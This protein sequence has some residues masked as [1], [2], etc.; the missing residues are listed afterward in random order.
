M[1]TY[2]LGIIILFFATVSAPSWALAPVESLVL[3][4]FSESYNEELTDPLN[5]V[6]TRDESVKSESSKNKSAMAM[7]RGFY[8]EGKNLTNY[9]KSPRTIRYAS[10]WDKLQVKRSTLALVQYIGLDLLSRAIPQYAKNL[11]FNR[12]DYTNLAENLVGNYCSNNLSVISK[13]ELLNNLFLK[14]DKENRFELPGVNK[15]II[16]PDNE[17]ANY[18][19]SK[20]GLEQEFL[21]SIK[22]FQ[23]VCSWNGNPNSAGLMA[24]I[25]RHSALMSFFIRQMSNQAIGWKEQDNTLFLKEDLKTVQVWCENLICRKVDAATFPQKVIYSVGGTNIGEDLKRL[26]CEE[27]SDETYRPEDYDDRIAKIM[28]KQSFDEQNFINSQFI[29]LITNVPDFLLRAP[30]FT[31]GED[32]LRASVDSTWNQWARKMS[33]SQSRDLFFEEPLTMEL[34]DR[35]RLHDFRKNEYR[36]GFDINL[37]EFDRINEQIGKVKL[38][39]LIKIPKAFIKYYR[40]AMLD[41]NYGHKTKEEKE[42]LKKRMRLHVT[43]DVERAKERFIIPPWR[44]D[45][46]G[47]IVEEL[48]AQIMEKA[49]KTMEFEAIGEQDVKV[50]V[51]YGV[52][53]LKY[54]NHQMNVLKT[55]EKLQSSSKK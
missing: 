53:A 30:K 16:Y 13:K 44:G 20:T 18:L 50:E 25:I 41:V 17:M 29:S 14:F 48:T 6:F 9:C 28:N 52:F 34:I 8:E 31:S 40:Q 4:N 26:Y 36:I 15:N 2:S 49:E 33:E 7:Y 1:K 23:A 32:V 51:N 19:P 11:E 27:F 37:G 35:S 10:E 55:Q 43:R 5:Y 21:F 42:H 47:L 22:L 46:E 3:G 39:F 24:P 54:I 38:Q 12:E 45:L